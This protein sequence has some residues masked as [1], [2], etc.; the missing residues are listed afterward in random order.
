[1][2]VFVSSRKMTQREQTA[3]QLGYDNGKYDAV[4][5]EKCDICRIKE[6]GTGSIGFYGNGWQ[7]CIRKL[8]NT[9]D[10]V[11]NH[12]GNQVAMPIEYCPNCGA[13]MDGGEKVND[14]I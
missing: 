11:I 8:G 7:V 2:S 14:Q 13:K 4:R 5:H 3:Y 6:T 10:M 9:F 12:C 1:M